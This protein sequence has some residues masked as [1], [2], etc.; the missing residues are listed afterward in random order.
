MNSFLQEWKAL[1]T[2]KLPISGKSKSTVILCLSPNSVCIF[3]QTGEI[4]FKVDP[5]SGISCVQVAH[6]VIKR[7]KTKFFLDF[8]EM[9]FKKKMSYNVL[10][11]SSKWGEKVEGWS[12]LL[13]PRVPRVHG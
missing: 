10:G 9:D 13:F 1:Y 7:E 6:V 12:R 2:D 8:V 4:I 11:Y 5:S 3:S